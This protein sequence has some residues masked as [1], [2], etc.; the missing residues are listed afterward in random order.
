MSRRLTTLTSRSEELA[1]HEPE[2]RRSE[3]LEH[4]ARIELLVVL[5]RGTVAVELRNQSIALALV[6]E[7][8]RARRVGDQPIRAKAEYDGE[9]SF[10][11]QNPLPRGVS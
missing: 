3:R 2:L 8:R 10:D 9:D 7:P 5:G 4:R 1:E 6:E 11:D